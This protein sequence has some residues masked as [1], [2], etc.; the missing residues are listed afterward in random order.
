MLK[1]SGAKG[2]IGKWMVVD[3][4]GDSFDFSCGF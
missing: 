2:V 3:D 4:F 1:K